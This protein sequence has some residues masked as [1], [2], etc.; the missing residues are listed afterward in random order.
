MYLTSNFEPRRV[1]DRFEDICAIPHGSGH[2][3]ALGDWILKLA[4]R[5]GREAVR[6]DAGNI[7]VRIPA[8]P[9]CE[10]VAP[11]LLQGHLDM[12]LAQEPGLDRDMVHEPIH[13]VL[14]GSILRADRTTLGADNAVGLCNMLAV[15][16]AD[17]LRYPPMELLF[18]TREETG[19]Q[20]I[21]AFDMSQIRSRRM[22]NMDMGDPD[23]MVIG[24]AGNAKFDLTRRCDHTSCYSDVLKI[25]IAGLRGGHGGLLAGKNHVSALHI[26]GR[27]LCDLCDQQSIRLVR[28]ESSPSNI[29]SYAALWISVPDK[30]AA[31]GLLEKIT[32]RLRA[33]MFE[34]TNLSI[35][36]TAAKADSAASVEDTRALADLLLLIPYDVSIRNTQHP[37]WVLASALLSPAAY[38]DGQFTGTLVIRANRDEYFESISLH[39][40]TLCRMTGVT[41][42]MRGKWIPAWPETTDTPLQ[43]A[44]RNTFRRLFGGEMLQEVE[45]GTVEVSVIAKAIPDM[46]IV[47]FAPR[48]RGAHTPKEYLCLDTVEPFWKHLT[49][50][51]ADLCDQ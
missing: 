32:Q 25:D 22:I 49:A 47:G 15:M 7:L 14:D 10:Q 36:V 2:E 51:L 11:I 31:E 29:P 24:S 13:L 43:I 20:G 16:D 21:Q 50:L 28:M 34:E 37:E 3:Q 46:D 6:D 18:T 12:V 30:A 1:L 41:A 42:N 40:S 45:H 23:C 39:L 4:N 27:I 38:Q 17:D 5:Y 8:T 26:A 44:C 33:E 9:G 19:L 48:S 35:T